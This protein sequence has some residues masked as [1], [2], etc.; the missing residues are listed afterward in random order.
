MG[1]DSLHQV[2]VLIGAMEYTMGARGNT[3]APLEL[4]GG[5]HLV[6]RSCHEHTECTVRH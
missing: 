5:V 4:V 3:E 2:N 6:Y 1:F